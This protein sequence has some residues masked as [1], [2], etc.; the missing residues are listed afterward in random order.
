MSGQLDGVPNSV[1]PQLTSA[2]HQITSPK[3]T[4]YNCVAWAAQDTKNWWQPGSYWPTQTDAGNGGLMQLVQLF[5]DLG[6]RE[7]AGPEPE[8][9][10]EKVALYLDAAGF[11]THAARQLSNGKWTSKLGEL[12][13]IEHDTPDDVAGGAYGTVAGFMKRAKP[14]A[15]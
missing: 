3:T 11:W 4:A 13:D 14:Q 7:C 1:F 12:E 15:A 2:N 8:L 9:G 6:Y 10:F 5:A